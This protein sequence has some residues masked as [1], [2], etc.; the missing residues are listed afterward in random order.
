M[1]KTI[2]PLS[3]TL[4]V[5]IMPIYQAFA[6]ETP[7]LLSQGGMRSILSTVQTLNIEINDQVS[8]GCLP[9]PSGL[10][11]ALEIALRQN[12]FAIDT[13]GSYSNGTV[14]ITAIGYETNQYNCAV[15]L[16]ADLSVMALVSVPY[17]YE[18]EGENRTFSSIEYEIGATLLTGSKNDMQS[19]LEKQSSEFG[20]ALFLSVSRSR[21]YI[22]VNFP[23]ILDTFEKQTGISLD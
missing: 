1:K 2:S 6:E 17:A 22:R 13:D 11:D 18:L 9:R 8:D 14:T 4:L 16:T 15:H 7:G 3:V 5:T 21:D 12:D 10:E 23:Q 20:D 19:R